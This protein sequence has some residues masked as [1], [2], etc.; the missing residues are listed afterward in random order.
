MGHTQ[1]MPVQIGPGRQARMM[2]MYYLTDWMGEDLYYSIT[3]CYYS[4]NISFCHRPYNLEQAT[5]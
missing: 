1:V 3:L 2:H 5:N 4:L